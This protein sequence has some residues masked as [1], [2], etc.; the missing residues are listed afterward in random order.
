MHKSFSKRLV[1]L[2]NINKFAKSNRFSTFFLSHSTVVS[3]YL[4][5]DVCYI[6]NRKH[7]VF[8]ESVSF[9]IA[10]IYKLSPISQKRYNIT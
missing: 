8:Y 5:I 1:S 3:P 7:E 10:N 2:Q 9:C 4:F 6:F